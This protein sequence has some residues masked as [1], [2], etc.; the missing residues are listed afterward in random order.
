MIER[1]TQ[2]IT[3][4]SIR[5]REK[6]SA[7]IRQDKPMNIQHALYVYNLKHIVLCPVYWPFC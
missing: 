3:L 5:F 4:S 2:N 1:A 6:S 7:Y